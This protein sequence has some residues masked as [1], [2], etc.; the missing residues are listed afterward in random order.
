[1][2]HSLHTPLCDLLDIELPIMLAGMS[3]VSY[4]PLAAAVSNAG[5]FGTLGMAGLSL[6]QI[7]QQIRAV[8]DLTDKPFGIDLLAPVPDVLERTADLS[9]DYGL[10]AFITGLGLPTGVVERL[11]KAGV[12]VMN[13]C[14]T[15]RHARKG[16][17]AGLDAV[18]VQGTEGGGHTG[19]VAGMA[20][21]P[22]AVDAVGVPVVAAGGIVDGRGIM[23]ALALGAQG[24]WLGTRF[25]AAR[26]AHAGE[27][28][29]DAIVR[30]GD[31]DTVVTR[32]YSGK[33]MRVLRNRYVDQWEAEPQSIQ[34][35]P[36][37][38]QVS[39]EN[40]ALGAIAGQTEG[41]DPDRSCMPMGQGAGG[42]HAVQTVAQ[43]MQSL[44]EEA[45]A[46]RLR[47]AAR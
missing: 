11:Q 21:I 1:M 32:C 27:A 8:R 12:R 37:Q 15:V 38:V 33:T 46:V 10:K 29:Q 6:R 35:F 3:G 4:A 39:V 7:E 5:G 42:I 28:F 24:V 16:A 23:A 13:V 18:I 47:L 9:I 2:V 30:A 14:G 31:E 44:M 20:L 25:V 45:K 26:E 34:P 22:Q 40:G 41:L 43:I 17:Q 19:R 36:A